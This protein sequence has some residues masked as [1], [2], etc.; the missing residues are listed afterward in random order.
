MVCDGAICANRV[1]NIQ[2]SND[3]QFECIMPNGCAGSIINIVAG[4]DPQNPALIVDRI[5]E[6]IF[7][8]VGSGAG[9]TVYIT[10]QLAAY[11]HTVEVESIACEKAGSCTGLT[12]LAGPGVNVEGSTVECQVPGACQNCFVKQG[13]NNEACDP[14][15]MEYPNMPI[16]PPAFG[17]PFPL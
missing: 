6:L 14:G 9:A 17:Y 16:V 15:Y 8:D 7:K 2:A 1:V 11:G 12:V 13:S 5:T 10:N 4:Y 3:Y